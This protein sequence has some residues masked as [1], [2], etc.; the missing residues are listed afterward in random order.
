MKK[1]KLPR[2]RI[3]I[4]FFVLLTITI[5]LGIAL[6][7]IN[8]VLDEDYVKFD[9]T[10]LLSNENQKVTIFD[11]NDN[12][13]ET[14]LK[15]NVN[16]IDIEKINQ[17]TINAFLAV[18]DKRFYEH[19]G[20]DFKRIIGALIKN[21]K[22]GTI[23]EGAS[24]ITQ[25]LAKNS[26][27]S[28][29]KSI[30]RKINEIILATKIENNFTKNEI[31]EMYLNTVYFGN[32]AY[33]LQNASRVF[34]SI[35]A[36][37][38]SV[39]QSAGLAG[40][41]KA[42]NNYSPIH[43]FNKFEER[44]NLVLKLMYENKMLNYDVYNIAINEEINI[45]DN[46]SLLLNNNYIDAVIK[47]S[48]N[49]LN[50]ST[51]KLISNNYVIKTYFDNSVQNALVYAINKDETKTVKN[52]DC[53]K[54]AI[55]LDNQTKGIKGFYGKSF[56]N[57]L[58]R[59]INPGSTIKPL[60]VYAPALEVGAISPIT[61]V[62][63]KKTKFSSDYEPTNYKNIYYGWT[64]IRNS[65]EKSLNIP[66]IKTANVIG[67][68][69][70]AN[71]LNKNGFNLNTD[72]LNLTLALGNID[73]GC[74]FEQLVNAYSTLADKG[75]YGKCSF[76]KEIT[77]NGRILYRHSPIKQ[78]VFSE[79]TSFLMSDMLKGVIKRGTAKNLNCFDFDIA[80]KT[81]TSGNKNGNNYD[82]TFCGYTKND[83]FLF[84]VG[85][86]DYISELPP[87]VT[88]GN[89]PVLMAKNYFKTFLD[90]V[91]YIPKNFEVPLKVKKFKIDKLSL[92]G[93]QQV[94]IADK[95]MKKSNIIEEYFNCDFAPREKASLNKKR[96]KELNLIIEKCEKGIKI[97]SNVENT[98]FYLLKSN[99]KK[100]IGFGKELT[101]KISNKAKIITVIAKAYV[102]GN[103]IE[104]SKNFYIDKIN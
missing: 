98:A 24:T 3:I 95:D 55:V 9:K 104:C 15:N 21:I 19:K 59:T 88:G 64:S 32:G 100:Y 81:G 84:W 11:C 90:S 63:D 34:F 37:D 83:T 22:Y 25:Q 79:E 65:V 94:R 53:D 1:K 48:C 67:L 102:D 26:F 91:N 52:T 73:G 38:L 12:P 75:Q 50:I 60:A 57:L 33:G 39:A 96:E 56:G 47:E 31:L 2:I 62:L 101:L 86:P 13:I 70:C 30:K 18:E 92:E 45:A 76:V 7:L 78:Q 6:C 58:N 43:R 68:E 14:T 61:P 20:I 10:K 66:A 71:Y 5:V 17:Y 69:K 89:Q 27:L 8:V 29:T 23:K 77:F 74:T 80:G 4:L 85:S 42:P 49:I 99:N 51:E 97:K 103:L 93:S 44:K 28:N 35:D 72:N 87:S 54:C 36:K 41:L 16:P 82:A 46:G 40:L